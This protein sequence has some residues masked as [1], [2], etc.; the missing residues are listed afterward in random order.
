MTF[1]WRS[2]KTAHNFYL[3][4]FPLSTWAWVEG[5]DRTRDCWLDNIGNLSKTIIAQEACTQLIV[6]MELRMGG[7]ICRP[8]S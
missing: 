3:H 5:Q 6:N 2:W 8:L 4:A 7:Q 1:L